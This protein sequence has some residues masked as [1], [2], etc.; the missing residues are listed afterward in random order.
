MER[1]TRKKINKMNGISLKLKTQLV[2]DFEL[3]QQKINQE[4]E[5]NFGVIPICEFSGH[6]SA[7]K[8]IFHNAALKC[9]VSYSD[10]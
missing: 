5:T 3:F 8:G 2:T 6:K 9:F 4:P 1:L 7:A 10:R